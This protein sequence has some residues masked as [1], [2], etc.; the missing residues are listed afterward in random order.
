MKKIFKGLFVFLFLILL[1]GCAKDY[2]EI[3]STKFMEVLKNETSYLVNTHTAL[4]DSNIETSIAAS[5]EK[6]QFLFFEFGSEKEAKEYVKKNYKDFSGY[7]YKDYG[8]YVEVKSSKDGYFRLV[9][10]N[11]IVISASS[12]IKS[13]KKEINNIF[14]KLGY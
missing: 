9:Q 13:S 8:T 11:K 5:S 6:A 7:K 4:Y 3:T 1:S 10:I 2:K 12:D 14:K